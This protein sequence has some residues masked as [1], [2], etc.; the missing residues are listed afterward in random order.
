ML[1]VDAEDAVFQVNTTTAIVPKERRGPRLWRRR[2][3]VQVRVLKELAIGRVVAA[4]EA[5]LLMRATRVLKPELLEEVPP[6]TSDPMT[7]RLRDATGFGTLK[8]VWKEDL[9]LDLETVKPE[10]D[11]FLTLRSLRHVMVHRLG[12]W[13]PGLDPQEELE[14]RVS[15]LGVDPERYRGP[16]PLA[17]D[18]V[19]R[20]A[21]VVLDLV[22]TVDAQV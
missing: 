17:P 2:P 7:K 1:S 4:G 3:S 8:K 10:F 15:A 21:R 5:Y 19:P 20:S 16:V 14:D 18:E 12:Y 22:D 6:A 13:Q 9:K 11:D